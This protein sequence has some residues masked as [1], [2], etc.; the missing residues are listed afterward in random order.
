MALQLALS[1][2]FAVVLF[3]CKYST[4][5]SGK[6]FLKVPDGVNQNVSFISSLRLPNR[7][8]AK[9]DTDSGRETNDVTVILTRIENE[10]GG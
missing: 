8:F 1:F 7:G 10:D 5:V 3:F 6:P 4:F 2:F 9:Q